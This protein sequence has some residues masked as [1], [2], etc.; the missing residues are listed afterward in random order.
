VAKKMKELRAKVE[1]VSQR[2]L[3]YHLIKGSGSK[4]IST[5]EQSVANAS[6]TKSDIDEVRRQN[7]KAKL[8][9]LRLI[10]KKDDDLKVIAVSATNTVGLVE[11][12]VIKRAYE[13]PRIHKKF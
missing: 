3:R 7:D 10:S 5:E 6:A 12:S 13:D 2:N 11:T 1:D 4:P 9:L 8:A